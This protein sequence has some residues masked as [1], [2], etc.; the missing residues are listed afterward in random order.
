MNFRYFTEGGA[1]H[2]KTLNLRP[3]LGVETVSGEKLNNLEEICPAR[4]VAITHT[5]WQLE[6]WNHIPP[7]TAR[8][9]ESHTPCDI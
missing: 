8:G 1:N 3:K 9:L 4:G 6:G 7:V 2:T 5:L